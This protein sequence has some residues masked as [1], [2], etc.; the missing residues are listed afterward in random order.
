MSENKKQQQL[1]EILKKYTSNQASLSEREAVEKWYAG[2]DS[3]EKDEQLFAAPYLKTTVE[4]RIK[5]RVYTQVLESDKINKRPLYFRYAAACILLVTFG[6]GWWNFSKQVPET[7]KK[8]VLISSGRGEQKQIVLADGSEVYLNS[9]S[10]LRIAADFGKIDRKITLKGEALFKVAKNKLKPFFI[11]TG[12][13]NTRVVGTSFNINAYP[14]M[15]RIK[16]SVLTGKV[17]VLKSEQ[18][19]EEVIAKDMTTNRTVSYD[20]SN[21]VIE[22]KTE[23]ALLCTS[24]KDKKL[25]IDNA[26]LAD[27]AEQLR[28]YYNVEVKNLSKHHRKDRYTIRFNH[29]PMKSVL[30]ILTLLTKRKFSYSN[31]QITIK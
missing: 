16:I 25:Y 7:L 20:K 28:Q 30:Q 5:G 19:R 1:K 11:R 24:W 6:A 9:N 17:M 22:L 3:E 31:H 4:Q 29:E 8:E 26:S 13:L 27:I 21:G 23:N 10:E 15:E 12:T 18:G 14:E 2:L